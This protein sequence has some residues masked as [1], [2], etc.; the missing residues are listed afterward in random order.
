VARL[1]VALRYAAVTAASGKLVVAGGSTPNG[2]A[3]RV[4]LGFDPA[5]R[6]LRAIAQLPAPLTHAAAATLH[7]FAYVI[8]G[9]GATAGTAVGRVWTIDPTAA[10]SASRG[11]S[12]SPAPTSRP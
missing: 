3:S 5:R 4:V 11:T 8:G 1:P 9:R 12:P 10:V 2:T 7:G 6:T